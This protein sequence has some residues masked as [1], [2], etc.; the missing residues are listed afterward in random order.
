MGFFG[1]TQTN[2]MIRVTEQKAQDQGF[3]LLL[4]INHKGLTVDSGLPNRM[5]TEGV[6]SVEYVE[7]LLK[8]QQTAFHGFVHTFMDSIN[9]R[10]NGVLT[11]VIKLKRA[12]AVVLDCIQHLLGRDYKV[13]TT[14]E[15]IEDKINI[16]DIQCDYLE[17]QSHR[18]NLHVDGIPEDPPESWAGTEVK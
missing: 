3:P 18:N 7:L 10:V 13:S 11:S 2:R 6:L 5:H 12:P 15:H 4:S 8:T 17:N 1:S 9:N 16:I 14:V